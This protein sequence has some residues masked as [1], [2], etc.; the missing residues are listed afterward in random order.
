MLSPVGL[1]VPWRLWEGDMGRGDLPADVWDHIKGLLPDLKS[2]FDQVHSWDPNMIAVAFHHESDIPVAVVCLIDTVRTVAAVRYALLECYAHGVY[3]RDVAQPREEMSAVWFERYYVDDAVFRLYAA[4]EHLAN[5]LILM[6]EI[7]DDQLA[8][9][10]KRTTS[11][12]AAI[13]RL[14]MTQKPDLGISRAL[15]ALVASKEWRAAMKYRGEWVHE[16]PPL[17]SG[18][19]TVYRRERRWR[20]TVKGGR[21]LGIGG[22]G[23]PR[24][25]TSELIATCRGALIQFLAVLDESFTQLARVLE[26]KGGIYRQP[27]G[28]LVITAYSRRHEEEQGQG[29]RDEEQGGPRAVRIADIEPI[30]VPGDRE[31]IGFWQHPSVDELAQRQG[32]PVVRSAEDLRADLWESDAEMEEF[33]AETYR[34]REHGPA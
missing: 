16:Q 30:A 31:G 14:L 17:V 32:V 2:R 3:Y 29:E 26:E 10:K 24:F 8:P 28:T 13:G 9:F 7:T 34:A 5:G 15:E 11:Q 23:A 19:G 25:E 27:D 22:G 20:A 6:F 18:L 21:R 33:L 4:A 1:G 12:Q